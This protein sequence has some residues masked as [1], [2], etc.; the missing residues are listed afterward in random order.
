M[1]SDLTRRMVAAAL[2]RSRCFSTPRFCPL[3]SPA[4][5]LRV[6][7]TACQVQE[8][9]G[10]GKGCQAQG[11]LWLDFTWR[12]KS[13]ASE[14]THGSLVLVEWWC[15]LGRPGAQS[16]PRPEGDF[17]EAE[18]DHRGPKH[19]MVQRSSVW[20]RCPLRDSEKMLLLLVGGSCS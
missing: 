19:N 1:R 7:E 5:C 3:E 20:F 18:E 14:A 2:Q 8:G 11:R 9:K 12:A 16:A 10:E 6:C 17:G 4:A 15:R 13:S